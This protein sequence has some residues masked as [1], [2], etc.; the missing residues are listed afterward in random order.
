[1]PL[2]QLQ[3][4]LGHKDPRTTQIYAE[5]SLASVARSYRDALG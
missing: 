3:K 2:D 1:M 4:F 5:S